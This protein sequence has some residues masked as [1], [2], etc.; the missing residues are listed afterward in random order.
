LYAR[1]LCAL[2]TRVTA[3]A[4]CGDEVMTIIYK[5]S[6]DER[7]TIE[8]GLAD[9]HEGRFA[10]EEIIAAIHRKACKGA[11]KIRALIVAALAVKQAP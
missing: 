10:D 8:R 6:D 2:A 5:L 1:S 4:G 7:A 9:M 11:G 3:S